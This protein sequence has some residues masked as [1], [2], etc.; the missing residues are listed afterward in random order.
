MVVGIVVEGGGDGGGEGGGGD[1]CIPR[2]NSRGKTVNA[3]E[4]KREREREREG[5]GRRCERELRSASASSVACDAH[6][7]LFV[8]VYRKTPDNLSNDY[9]RRCDY[10]RDCS[11]S[12]SRMCECDNA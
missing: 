2:L 3:A 11:C 10:H 1:G 7:R 6:S 8:V 12:R 5:G 4:R 9:H